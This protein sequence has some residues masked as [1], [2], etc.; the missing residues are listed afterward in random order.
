MPFESEKYGIF[1]SDTKIM[2]TLCDASIFRYIYIYLM[3]LFF[4]KINPINIYIIAGVLKYFSKRKKTFLD[5][6]NCTVMTTQ[7]RNENLLPSALIIYA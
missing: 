3:F 5:S 6:I 4:I 1:N 7:I 2:I